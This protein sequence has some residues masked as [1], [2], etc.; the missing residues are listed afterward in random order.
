MAVRT[1][2]A[3]SVAVWLF[4][5]A[6]L[7]AVPA[8]AGGTEVFEQVPCPP[9]VAGAAGCYEARDPDGAWLLAAIPRE[10]N[11]RL[12]VHAHGGPRLG[13]PQAGDAA[14][15]LDRFAAV[16]RAGYAWIGSTYRRGGYGVRRA[17]ADVDAS[18]VAF[19]ARW[20]RPERTLLHG[21]SWGGN[22]AAKLAELHALDDDGRPNYDAV[23]TTNGVLAGGTRA[24]GFRADLRAVYQ[25]Y[26]R[27][28]PKPDEPQYPLW[29]GLPLDST[30][31][32]AG[33]RARVDDCTGIDR[34][35]SRRTPEQAARLADILAVT[36]IAEKQLV[37]HL[38]WGT[39]HFRDLVQRHLGGRNPFDNSRTVYRGSRDDD[40]LNGGVERFV[41]DPAAVA[42]LAYDADLSGL[43]VL[44]TLNLHVEHDP[45]VSPSAL[46]AYRR[47]VEAA[48]RG[49][50][51]AQFR[52]GGDDHSRPGEAAV[53]AALR[54][55]EAWLDTGVKPDAA[56]LEA[57]CRAVASGPG[58]CRFV[59]P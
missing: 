15:D 36:G 54:A 30:M 10:W 33:L 37:A 14:E 12:V 20:G 16:V 19:Q 6:L 22:V 13:E 2:Q 24:Y 25:Y 3:G 41:A 34:P 52:I 43:I 5:A 58:D 44:P 18:R 39:F 45:V 42:A 49:H 9:S 21:Q 47:V 31:T 8:R 4:V 17:A 38:A 53:L 56:A 23:L 40:A 48:G 26:C 46:D 50:L 35:P 59:A 51:L 28:H 27:N 32:R 1:V 11:R 29:Q 55:L 57:A 7:P